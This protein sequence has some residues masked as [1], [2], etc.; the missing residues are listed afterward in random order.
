LSR[1]HLGAS[2][3]DVSRLSLGSW[4]TFER[5]PRDVGLA[6]LRKAREVGINFLDD[7]RYNDETGRAPLETGYSE[8]LFGEL[9]RATGWK[10]DEVLLA[11]KLWWEFWPEQ[12]AA[13][14]LEA[15]LGRM[16]LHHLDLAYAA[17]PPEGLS[18]EQ[19]VDEVTALIHAGKLRAW[20]VLNWPAALIAEAASIAERRS[21][22]GPCAA[23]LPYNLVIRA[24]VEGR[25]IEEALDYAG[26]S[27][28][29]S[30]TLYG[31]ALSG[32]YADPAARG[33]ITAR[34]D[35]R[36]YAEP[37]GAA[38]ELSSLAHELGTRPATLAIAFAL[39]N[40]RVAT[41]LFGAT[42]P[43][44]IEENLAAVEL[45]DHLDASA[46]AML[47]GIGARR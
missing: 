5:V 15:S 20:G 24:A 7:A 44:Q 45:A 19:V 10:R 40:P 36:D 43:A 6:V 37:L 47:R 35:D 17:E 42:A 18:V 38:G 27:V 8:V 14:E 23:Q 3:L 39:L 34:I 12:D 29:A 1:R 25:E 16:Q 13:Q 30:Y 26:T 11:N 22:A 31:G 4:R 33:R 32:K 9:F 41:A 28:V 46:I 21:V 2:P